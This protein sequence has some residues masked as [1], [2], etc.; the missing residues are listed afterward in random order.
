LV[1]SLVSIAELVWPGQLFGDEETTEPLTLAVALLVMGIL[2]FT[3]AVYIAT[4]VLFLMWLYR[5]HENLSAF[6]V[7]KRHLQYSSGWAVG[8]FF[9]PFVN[10]VVPYRAIKELWRKSVP[11]SSSMFFSELSPPGFFPL[12]WG[13]WIISNFIDQLYFRLT[14]RESVS[15]DVTSTIGVLSGVLGLIAA[16]LAV[17]VVKEIDRQ[18]TESAR[19]IQDLSSISHPPAPPEFIAAAQAQPS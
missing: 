2:L 19:L 11:N 15:T 5:A 9:V 16:L 8:S 4:V 3:I 6:G 18:Q 1:S 13:F 7:E 14:W 12:W 10:L 17:K